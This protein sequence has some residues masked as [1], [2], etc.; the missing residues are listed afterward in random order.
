VKFKLLFI[1][2]IHYSQTRRAF[3]DGRRRSKD[4]IAVLICANT[5]ESEKMSLLATGKYENCEVPAM[6]IQT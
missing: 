2:T 6:Y 1:V 3:S 5:D 4:T